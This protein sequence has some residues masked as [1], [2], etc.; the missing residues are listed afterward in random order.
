MR[1]K[2]IIA[3]VVLSAVFLFAAMPF[4]VRPR[5]PITLRHVKSVRSGNVTTVTFEITNHT[6]DLY[7]FNPFEVQV[8]NGSVWTNVRG[9]DDSTT[10]RAILTPIPTIDPKGRAT[11]MFDVTNLPAGSVVRFKIR[12]AKALMGVSGFL[13]RVEFN[14]KRLGQGGGPWPPLNPNDKR[15]HVFGLPSEVTSE[16]FVE[17]GPK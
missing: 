11:Y 14:L 17:Q 2:A 9:F 8:Q 4:I 15:T 7:I 10:L 1:T 16:E 5:Q 3:G 13:K 12:P 6:A